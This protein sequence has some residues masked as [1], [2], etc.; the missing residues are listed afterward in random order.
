MAKNGLRVMDSDLHVVEPRTLWEPKEALEAMDV[1]GIDVGILSRTW[2]ASPTSRSRA[3]R[4]FCGTI[5]HGCTTSP[6]LERRDV[7]RGLF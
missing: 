1:E 6:L 3:S 7:T 5:A 2:A 4:R